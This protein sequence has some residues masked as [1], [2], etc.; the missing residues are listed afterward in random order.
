MTLPVGIAYGS[1]V[2]LVMKLLREVADQNPLVLKN[3]EPLVSFLAFDASSLD[4]DL[5]PWGA[6]VEQ[7]LTVTTELHREI[8][9]RFREASVEI[10]FPQQDLHPPAVDED[11]RTGLASVR[12]APAKAETNSGQG[13]PGGPPPLGRVSARRCGRTGSRGRAR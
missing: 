8:D 9:R 1:D 5:R 2:P 12:P 6:D 13:S 3:P 11:A 7:R 4:F 10:A